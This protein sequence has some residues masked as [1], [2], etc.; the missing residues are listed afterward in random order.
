[1]EDINTIKIYIQNNF[2]NISIIGDDN[3]LLITDDADKSKIYKKLAD[4]LK[5]KLNLEKIAERTPLPPRP[6]TPSND[7]TKAHE[8]FIKKIKNPLWQN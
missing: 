5:N 1:M 7:E 3:C 4:K 8:E 6:H 2:P